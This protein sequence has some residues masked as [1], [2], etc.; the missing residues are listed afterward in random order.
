MEKH[1]WKV[2]KWLLIFKVLLIFPKLVHW[3]PEAVG[4]LLYSLQVSASG[5]PQ[6]KWKCSQSATRKADPTLESK[7]DEIQLTFER[8]ALFCLDRLAELQH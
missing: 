8:E 4:R 3:E 7:F 5:Y 6:Y 1:Q 2:A